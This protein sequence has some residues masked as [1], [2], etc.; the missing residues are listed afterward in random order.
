VSRRLSREV[1]R[2]RVVRHVVVDRLFR[3]VVEFFLLRACSPAPFP[4]VLLRGADV[5]RSPYV[6]A[7]RPVRFGGFAPSLCAGLCACVFFSFFA[8]AARLRLVGVIVAVVVVVVVVLAHV[9]GRSRVCVRVVTTVSR[10]FFV[11]RF[12]LFGQFTPVF[13]AV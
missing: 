13:Y 9:G 6:R 7:G 4:F 5:C 10:H 3:L 1:S 2:D 8:F 11:R 12:C